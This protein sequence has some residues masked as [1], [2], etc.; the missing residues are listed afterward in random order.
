MAEL[1]SRIHI[2][3]LGNPNSGKSTLFN[4]LTGL[5]QKTGNYAGVTVDKLSGKFKIE[6]NEKTYN[7]RITDLPGIYSLFASSLDEQVAVKAIFSETEK[8]DLAIVVADATNL[9]RNL[10]LAT[11]VIDLGIKTVLVLNMMDEANEQ[12]IEI[13]VT[14]IARLMDVPVVSTNSRTGEG[15]KELKKAILCARSSK[16]KFFDNNIISEKQEER[17]YADFVQMQFHTK[18]LNQYAKWQEADKIYRFKQISYIISKCVKTPQ[19]LKK[20]IFSAKLDK[21]LTHPVLG[22]LSLFAVLFVIF[23]FIFYLAEYPM[24]GIEQLFLQIGSFIQKQFSEGMLRDLISEG[25]ING[26]SGVMMFIPQIALLFFFIALLEDSGYM[27]RAGFLSDKLMRKVG[28]NGRSIIPLIS[29]TACAVPSIMSTRTISNYKDRLITIFILPLVSCSARLPVYT[30]LI[31]V[32]LPNK[33]I[34][35]VFNYK[36][37]ALFGLYF[38]GFAFSFITAFF[39]KRLLKSKDVSHY[40]ME[41]PVYR[42][43]QFKNVWLTVYNKVKVFVVDAGKIIVSIAVV[44]WFLSSYGP[45]EKFT[46]LKEQKK[47]LNTEES[48]QELKKLESDMLENSYVGYMGRAVEPVIKPLGYDW[49]I[50]IAIITSFAAREVFVGTMSTIYGAA[51]NDDVEGIGA[52]LAKEKKKDGTPVYSAATCFSLL[53]F[54]VFAM[55]CMSTVAVVKRETKSWKWPAVQF[56]Y[57]TTL[58]WVAAWSVFQLMSA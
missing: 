42:V 54:Y 2:A 17:S 3:L 12:G 56:V 38:L 8:P 46:L 27:A 14:E 23:Q 49:K 43:P 41:M 22:Y 7:V 53:V 19:Q 1:K 48:K 10:L 30:L 34:G 11:Q 28:L 20:K 47:N 5:N 33:T 6:S 29:A 31:S 39:L 25:V 4:A 35:G 37:L 21:I 45:G 24:N 50:G 18:N 58:A 16:S 15:I 52:R 32:M 9:K 36:G 51:G 26:V 55:Q 13:N 44:L 57:L 40:I